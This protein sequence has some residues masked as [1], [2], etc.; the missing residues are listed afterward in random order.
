MSSH[1]RPARSEAG[2]DPAEA[3][4]E[5]MG[6][7]ESGD[8][9]GAERGYRAILRVD[10]GSVDALHYLGILKAQ[11]NACAEA[12]TLFDRALAAAP[13]AADLLVSRGTAL[14]TLGRPEE[15]L[16]SYER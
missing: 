16:A 6:L 3:L 1:A 4:R 14:S 12:L 7:H 2:A 11:Q 8:L 9:A 15:A 5:A 13:R 10:P